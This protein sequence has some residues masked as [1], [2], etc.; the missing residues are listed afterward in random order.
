LRPL[1][2]SWLRFVVCPKKKA[3]PALPCD[4]AGLA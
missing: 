3:L 1:A 2:S 4:L